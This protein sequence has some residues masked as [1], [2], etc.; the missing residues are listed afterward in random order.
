MYK[1]PFP[2]F[3]KNTL[4]LF[5]FSIIFIKGFAQSQQ[6]KGLIKDSISDKLLE[7][8]TIALYNLPDSSLLKQTRSL[9]TGF[10]FRN[11]NPGK[12]LLRTSFVGYNKSNQILTVL[13]TDTLLQIPAIKL[14]TAANEAMMQVVVVSSIPPV[15]SRSDTTA[16]QAGAFKTRPDATVEDL[17]KK[18]PGVQVSKDGEVTVNGQKVDKF[19][20]DGKEIPLNDARAITRNL[21]A[22][23]IS[24]LETFDRRSDDSKFTGIRDT[25]DAKAINFKLKKIYRRSITGKAFAGFGLPKFYG[26]GGNGLF[27]DTSSK[28][29]FSAN[30]NNSSDVVSTNPSSRYNSAGGLSSF[31]R[32]NLN[33]NKEF[34]KDFNANGQYNYN[35][36]NVHNS[37]EDERQTFLTDSSL[38]S[39]H[40]NNNFNNNTGQY[41][42][43]R[44]L[45]RPDSTTEI[46]FNPR[47]NRSNNSNSSL[48][49]QQV[50]VLKNSTNY[51]SSKSATGS[52]TGSNQSGIGADMYLRHRFYK[53]GE[54]I[55]FHLFANL[56]SAI[57]SG[58]FIANTLGY[59]STGKT[60]YRQALNQR[61]FQNSPSLNA[62][63]GTGYTY[64]ITPTLILDA[65]YDYY[66]NKQQ[67]NKTTYNYDSLSAKYDLLDTLT[68]NNFINTL[69]TNKI[70]IGL[71]QT[72][73]TFRYQFGIAVQHINQQ[74]NNLGGSQTSISQQ[75]NNYFPKAGFFY[76]I[77]PQ[78][79]L[80]LNYN[81]NTVAPSIDQLRP[82]PDFSNPLIVRKGNLNLRPEFD[83]NM[84][85]NYRRFSADKLK[86]LLLSL[87]LNLAENKF[88]Q[89]TL[90]LPGGVQQVTA[91]NVSG[92]YYSNFSINYNLPFSKGKKGNWRLGSN[93][94][95]NHT[96]GLTNGFANVQ[97]AINYNPNTSIN[98]SPVERLLIE[99]DAQLWFSKTDNSFTKQA[100]NQTNQRYNLGISYELPGGL[101]INTDIDTQ[102]TGAQGNL[103]G[104]TVS[105]WNANISKHIFA[106]KMGEI[107]LSAFDILNTNKGFSTRVS[108]NYIE[109]SNTLVMSHLL[110]VSFIYHF[111]VP[112]AG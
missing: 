19:Y 41:L 65:S 70:S 112:L 76:A 67:S 74:S 29:T 51:L 82:L 1:N 66:H 101:L 46:T 6:I 54:T 37:R 7:G 8:A 30:R 49:G 64:P 81:G 28:I 99:T 68:T 71:N 27:S 110:F 107:K 4:L 5:L 108:D 77:T 73:T 63:A 75:A 60:I 95:Y 12:Y 109:T 13:A 44:L 56:R 33:G 23:M 80:N 98:Y 42:G 16:Y 53:K 24:S 39:K 61:Y 94:N 97:R 43:G 45:Y 10:I 72:G 88:T 22:D 15:I 50:N 35:N 89:S 3:L 11:I 47:L 91:V 79:Q 9:K 55:R 103:A 100:I 111:K 31:T 26:V 106:K 20:I 36:A 57:D 85:I 105:L 84:N 59:D 96:A 92:T 21:S 58:N 52:N 32:I 69:E 62:G 102:I 86:S 34:S 104:R 17:L 87:T 18:L 38:L 14:S 78:Q 83:H 40:T 25:D 90:L 93:F 48:D 2:T